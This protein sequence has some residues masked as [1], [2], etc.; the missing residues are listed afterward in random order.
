MLEGLSA[1]IAD[2][3]DFRVVAEALSG[4]DALREADRVRPDVAVVD[5]RL[6]GMTGVEVCEKLLRRQAGVGVILLTS[7][8]NEKVMG[9][10]LD[11][12]AR[13][14]VLK[15]SSS[16]TL[17]QAV[18]TVAEGGTYNGSEGGR[19][20]RGPRPAGEEGQGPV[21]V[22]GSGDASLGA[23]A[24]GAKQPG[25]RRRAR[26]LRGDGQDP[27][28]QRQAQAGGQGPGRGGGD[29]HPGGP[30]LRPP[31]GAP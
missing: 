26:Y 28:P 3:P 4:E 11:A 25:H 21:R 30:G 12:G 18:R 10:G 5:V 9:A 1:V 29:R 22:D 6:P 19:Q 14:F 8:P 20:V 24:P 13:G 23:V 17:R 15:E 16:A 7:F 31:L 2:D 27:S